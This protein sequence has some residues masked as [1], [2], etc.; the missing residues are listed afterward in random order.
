MGSASRRMGKKGG[1]VYGTASSDDVSLVVYGM[2]VPHSFSAKMFRRTLNLSLLLSLCVIIGT[3]LDWIFTQAQEDHSLR[4]DDFLEL[5][6]M[7]IFGVTVPICGFYAA[8]NKSACGM[9]CFAG[10]NFLNVIT[11]AI[12]ATFCM[13][14]YFFMQPYGEYKTS[15]VFVG[16][17]FI[18]VESMAVVSALLGFWWANKL[19]SNPYVVEIE[20][21]E[22]TYSPVQYKGKGAP[23]GAT[24]NPPSGTGGGYIPGDAQ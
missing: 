17:L 6:V 21:A 19:R 16:G 13:V 22:V 3:C 12:G 11:C 18:I 23:A 10:C 20:G 1:Q 2:E 7:L 24:W 15:L 5:G 14:T 4:S 9:C 8:K